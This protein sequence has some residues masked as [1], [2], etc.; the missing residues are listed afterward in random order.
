MNKNLKKLNKFI[1]Y[2]KQQGFLQWTENL[3]QAFPKAEI[4]LVGG[5]VRDALLNIKKNK[6]LDFVVRN[7]SLDD[8]QATLSDLGWVE[9]LGKNFGVLKFKPRLESGQSII[10]DIALPRKEFSTQPGSYKD[11][12]V[13]FDEVEKIEQ[14]LS[15][16]DFTINALAVRLDSKKIEILDPFN[17]LQDLQQKLIRCVGDAEQRLSEDYNRL[18]RAV[19]FAC[20]LDFLI[21]KKTQYA[22]KELATNLNDIDSIGEYITPREMIATEFL[23][24]LNYNHLKAI[25]LFDKL[26]FL[27]ILMPEV[28]TM[29]KCPQP[30]IYHSE[31][32]VWQHTWLALQNLN[33]KKF[34]KFSKKLDKILPQ[35][36]LSSA[37]ENKLELILALFLHDIGKPLT[38]QTPRK[39]KTDRIRFND[40]DNVGADLAQKI[41][42]RFKLSSPEKYGI[43]CDNLSWLVRKH[44]MLVH[45]HSSEFRPTTIE[46]NFFNEKYPGKNLIKLTWLDISATH[47][48]DF[49]LKPDLVF[50]LLKRIKKMKKAVGHKKSQAKLPQP[51]LTGHEIMQLLKIIPGPQIGEI[52]NKLREKQLSGEIQ[53]KAQAQKFIKNL[54]K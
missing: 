28:L 34:K 35:T 44:M 24:A 41:C 30:K 1:K 17:G 47:P 15:R 13:I 10:F 2:L 33:S 26:N 38:L 22:I 18:L 45:G 4:Y 53:T 37:L 16:R 27:K 19:R 3:K 5:A 6:D 39:H 20:Q 49:K 48:R 29:K 8:L 36:N 11:F 25:Q 23:K 42:E 51:L 21:E 32:D 52:K 50:A 12:E 43:S 7:V 31:G 46:K 9:L 14:D 54:P 40:H